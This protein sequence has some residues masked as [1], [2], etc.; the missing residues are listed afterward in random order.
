[1]MCLMKKH[2]DAHGQNCIYLTINYAREQISVVCVL[3]HLQILGITTL[4]H[5]TLRM[6]LF[7][8]MY[9]SFEEFRNIKSAVVDR[10]PEPL[11][12]TISQISYQ[13]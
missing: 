13:F 2:I 8:N 7:S 9:C 11:Q 5:H 4:S 6:I 1:M 10:Y 3:K 12:F